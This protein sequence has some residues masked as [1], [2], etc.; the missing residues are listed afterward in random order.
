MKS[1]TITVAALE[2][3]AEALTHFEPRLGRL[4]HEVTHGGLEAMV[5]AGGSELLCRMIPGYFN[6]RGAEEPIHA[7]V[8]GEDGIV[9]P[10]RR[11]GGKRN[12][13][14]RFGEVITTR[15]GYGGREECL[16][17]GCEVAVHRSQDFD[18]FYDQARARPQMARD[19]GKLRVISARWQGYRDAP[20]GSAR[21]HS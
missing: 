9:R 8:V 10:H 6:R 11:E 1:H 21:S 7:R 12:L 2:H 15:R 20:Q 13:E 16:A 14:T 17:P 19:E 3:Y 18:T 5:Q 4:T